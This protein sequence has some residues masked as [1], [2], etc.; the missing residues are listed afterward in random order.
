M[1]R[2]KEVNFEYLR[3]IESVFN[4]FESGKEIKQKAEEELNLY[5]DEI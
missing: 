2:D 1:Y 3:G 5:K 4:Y